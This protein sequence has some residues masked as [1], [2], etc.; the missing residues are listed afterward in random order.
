MS[1]AQIVTGGLALLLEIGLLVAFARLGLMLDGPGRWPA[2]LALVGTAI[3][4]WWLFAAPKAPRRLHDAAL[5]GFKVAMFLAG[6]VA[7]AD[8]DIAQPLAVAFFLLAVIQ[9][10]LAAKL[11]ML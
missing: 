6:A 8:S 1:P 3:L 11:E 10:A 9:M 2:A 4:L 5:V 7:L